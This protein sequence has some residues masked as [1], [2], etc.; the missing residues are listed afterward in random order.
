MKPDAPIVAKA[1]RGSYLNIFQLNIP[2]AMSK[3]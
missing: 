1:Y 3:R 2:M